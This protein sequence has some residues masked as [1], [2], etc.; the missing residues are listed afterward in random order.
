MRPVLLVPSIKKNSGTGHIKR[1]LGLLGALRGGARI[2]LPPGTGA[3]EW[4]S[5]EI[6]VRFAEV[7]RPEQIVSGPEGDWK[8]VLF[9]RR[10]TTREE[11]LRFST[12]HPSVG[13]D[14]GGPARP[15]FSYLIDTF[16]RT[17][18]AFPPNLADESL[19][20]DGAAK[21][22]S[23]MPD[24]IRRVLLT[25]GGV[26]QAGL[27]GIALKALLD[28]GLIS[29]ADIDIVSGPAF[30]R[31]P[32]GN[33][34]RHYSGMSDI[35]RLFSLYDAVFTSFGITPYEVL[36]EGGRP[37]LVNPTAYH[38]KLA[39]KAGFSEL[40]TGRISGSRLKK[41][42][43]EPR[44]HLNLPEIMQETSPGGLGP[45]LDKLTPSTRRGCPVCGE[46]RG[47]QKYRNGEGTFFRCPECRVI[48][49]E[50]FS[51]RR[52]RY[53]RDYFFEDYRKQYGKTYLEDFEKIRELARGR[54]GVLGELGGGLEGKRLLDVG[55]AY[56]PFLSAAN[57][58]GCLSHGIDA[59][60]DAVRHVRDVLRIPAAAGD[61]LS[62]KEDEFPGGRDF[63]IVTLWY[64]IEHFNPVGEALRRLSR[65]VRPG[66]FL[67]LSTPNAAGASSRFFPE[68][69]YE[70]SPRD[71]YTIWD[72]IS[73][74]R[75]LERFGFRIRRVR[76]TG[77]HPE[78][79]PVPLKKLPGLR[80][81]E[82]TSR[83]LGLGDTF[84][85][86]AEKASHG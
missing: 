59:A 75:I 53:D 25:F 56:G 17:G 41:I 84:E 67:A 49:R 34:G 78:R 45:I 36:R 55:C 81:C 85:I 80:G 24:R 12:G 71:H 66:G 19:V 86:Y 31:I 74:R 63:D 33:F 8:Y 30:S 83:L 15:F 38:R 28:T 61:F 65:L 18:R 47:R 62:L 58:A 40:G 4:G 29:P 76:I 21:E 79:F 6:L 82:F 37:V 20:T 10:G 43:L 16:P 57:E 44:K 5:E 42:I 27:T 69:F 7:L 23:E 51:A 26:D 60:E 1:C 70:S 39:R 2:L 32:T 35:R 64:V 50:D 3:G 48:Y 13:L 52:I 77:H 14:E 72:S 73:A 11:F 68:K 46:L 22:S 54:L 9:D